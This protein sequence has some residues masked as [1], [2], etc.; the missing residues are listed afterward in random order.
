MHKRGV[1]YDGLLPEEGGPR[2]VK[3]GEG[4]EEDQLTITVLPSAAEYSYSVNRRGE[5]VTLVKTT[6][7]IVSLLFLS[8]RLY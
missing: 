7:P 8:L 1:G 5:T 2:L 6:R 3:R 4:E